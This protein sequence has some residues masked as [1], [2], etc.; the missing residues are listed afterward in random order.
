MVLPQDL[1]ADLEA[2]PWAG[3][4]RVPPPCSAPG[5]A[6]LS[7]EAEPGGDAL[8]L[9]TPALHLTITLRPALHLTWALVMD[10]KAVAVAS[11]RASRPYTFSLA[12]DRMEHAMARLPGDA[13]YG[14]GDKTGPL[15]LAGRRLR[16]DMTDALGYCARTGDPLYK[17]WPFLLARDAGSGGCYGLL[18]DSLPFC[19]F[20]LGA[21]HCN[22]Y[23]RYRV[24]QSAGDLDYYFLAG[25]QLADVVRRFS[26]L[27]GA[28]AMP[29][30]WSLGFALTAMPLADAADAQ[31]AEQ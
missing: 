2:L 3:A 1:R 19:A 23:G 27:S 28:A 13:F 11:D 12:S 7:V 29:P 21:E 4:P 20:D 9:R 30:R 31:A 26:W 16:T 8:T 25:P 10:G 18:Y 14:L 5:P 15:N 22:Y 17:H 6:W 24:Y